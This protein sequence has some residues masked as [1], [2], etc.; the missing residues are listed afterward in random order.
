MVPMSDSEA[1]RALR[2]TAKTEPVT[3]LY[4]ALNPDEAHVL[5]HNNLQ[6]PLA[7]LSS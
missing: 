2:D 5:G 4:N 6:G 3:V 1:Y 7:I